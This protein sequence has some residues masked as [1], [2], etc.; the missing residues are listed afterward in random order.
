MTRMT[1]TIGQCD[2][3]AMQIVKDK[4]L[5]GLGAPHSACRSHARRTVRI[6]FRALCLSQLPTVLTEKSASTSPDP[7]RPIP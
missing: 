5:H 6:T 2:E 7:H 1:G 4:T 3:T